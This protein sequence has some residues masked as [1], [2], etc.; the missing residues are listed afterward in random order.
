MRFPILLGAIFASASLQAQNAADG[1]A[2]FLLEGDRNAEPGAATAKEGK[3]D[4]PLPLDAQISQHIVKLAEA[5]R[6]TRMTFM[7]IV[8]DDVARLC[9][10]DAAQRE[11]LVLAAKGASERSMKDW[12]EKAER[13]FRTRLES[14]DP[15]AAKA[16]LETMGSVN[17]GGNRSDEEGESLD[18]W[19]ESLREVLSDDQVKRYETVLE[20][21]RT[22][23]I[24][25][26]AR[27][28]LSSI[29][30]HVRLTPDQRREIGEIVRNSAATYLDEVRRYWADYF[31]RGMLMS[32]ANAADEE[33]LRAI[34]TEQQFDRFREATA[35]FDHFWDQ[36][37]KLKR[38]KEKAAERRKERKAAGLN[39]EPEADGDSDTDPEADP[40]PE[41]GE[42]PAGEPR[43]KAVRG[44]DGGIRVKIN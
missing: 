8:I 29:D 24:D 25:A 11:Q 39:T 20:Q 30:D 13:Y 21:R 32:L 44:A 4:P 35:N 10:L 28:S 33:T 5:E 41:A 1:P 43:A 12:H 19:K 15:D 18:L 16:M 17:F 26:F 34:L 31:E 27:M 22:E 40:D 37:R 3:T 7:N 38:A 6:E 36:K 23:R 9:E 14:T 42:N 2:P